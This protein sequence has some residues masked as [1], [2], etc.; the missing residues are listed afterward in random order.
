MRVSGSPCLTLLMEIQ[1]V[2]LWVQHGYFSERAHKQTEKVYFKRKH[3]NTLH[4]LKL[5][6]PQATH[7]VYCYLIFYIG[8]NTNFEIW[9]YSLA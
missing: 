2:D 5:L 7:N 4:N 6:G 9:K 8:S 3:T 1:D